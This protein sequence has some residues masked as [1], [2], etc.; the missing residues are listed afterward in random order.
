[1]SK[2]TAEKVGEDSVDGEFLF[3]VYGYTS[4]LRL[5]A[6][7]LRSTT[8]QLKAQMQPRR[9]RDRW[10]SDYRYRQMMAA[11][12]LERAKDHLDTVQ[13]Q[14]KLLSEQAEKFVKGQL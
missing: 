2:G 3:L 11:E 6:S 12:L 4:R 10:G 1:M 5:H 7:L 13:A 9:K 14:M 8:T